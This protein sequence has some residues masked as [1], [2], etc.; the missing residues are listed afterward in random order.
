MGT[1]WTNYIKRIFVQYTGKAIV[2]TI[3]RSSFVTF[4]EG[5][6]L[7]PHL[8]QSIAASMRHNRSTV[9]GPHDGGSEPYL[10]LSMNHP[11]SKPIHALSPLQALQDYDRRTRIDRNQQAHLYAEGLLQKV[12]NT[13]GGDPPMTQEEPPEGATRNQQ[14]PTPPMTQE[15]PPEGATHNQQSLN[16][17]V[18]QEELPE[19]ATR[20]QQSPTPPMTQEDPPEGAT[21]NQQSLNS[22]VTQEDPPEGATRNQLSLNSPMTRDPPEGATRNQLSLNSPMTQDPPEGATCNQQSL[23]SPMTQLEPPEVGEAVAVV[24]K[25]STVARPRIWIGRCLRIDGDHVVITPFKEISRD[26]FIFQV[27]GKRQRAHLRD[28]VS[29]IDLT[30]S[31]TDNTYRLRTTRTEIHLCLSPVL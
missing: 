29:P 11:L 28:V 15:E 26:V 20:N 23:N 24:E 10:C 25:D 1:K 21:L 30:H 5:Q 7:P 3:L 13:S 27:G 8:K 2:P 19:G 22:P 6:T 9:S 17:P 16:S 14:S 31:A 12:L 18:T 4:N